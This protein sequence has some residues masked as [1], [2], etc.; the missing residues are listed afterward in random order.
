[1]LCVLMNIRSPGY[2][3]F[4]RKNNVLPL[5]CTRTIREYFS[6]INMK[7]GFDESFS[8]LLKKHLERKT[9][10]QRH[11]ILLLDEIN[12]RKSVCSRNLTY[13]G[14]IDFGDDGPK[15]TNINEQADH[16]LVL[17]L[18]PLADTY[19][20][21]IAVFASKNSVDGT[22]LAKLVVKAIA[23]LEESGAKIHWRYC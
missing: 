16:G 12:L 11:D 19:T 5:P 7:C 17:M 6:L 3:E 9:P 4:L 13:A 22:E 21:P 23:Y 1:M 8:K 10:L 2:Y 18:Q 15:S 20:Q 14:L